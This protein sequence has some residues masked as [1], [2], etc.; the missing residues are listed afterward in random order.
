MIMRSKGVK[1]SNKD[2]RFVVPTLDIIELSKKDVI[3]TSGTCE[4]TCYGHCLGD[5]KC[6]NGYN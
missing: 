4:E 2:N 6:I 3:A 1:M 5:Y